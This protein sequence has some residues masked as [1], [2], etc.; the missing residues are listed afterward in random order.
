M[1]KGQTM[2]LEEKLIEDASSTLSEI[3]SAIVVLS[4]NADLYSTLMGE[5][6]R[7]Y[8]DWMG[9]I[10]NCAQTAE[11]LLQDILVLYKGKASAETSHATGATERGIERKL[12]HDINNGLAP[13]KGFSELLLADAAYEELLGDRYEVFEKYLKIIN[14]GETL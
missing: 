12:V 5:T 13:V 10:S 8:T 14:S 11:G 1:V 2:S 4:N 6:F 3:K 9:G 7:T